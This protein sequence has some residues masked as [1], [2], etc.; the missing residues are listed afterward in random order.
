MYTEVKI[1]TKIAPQRMST[2]KKY[3]EIKHSSKSSSASTIA[4]CKSTA[5]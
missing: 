2:D 5:Y 1:R 3:Q 4:P